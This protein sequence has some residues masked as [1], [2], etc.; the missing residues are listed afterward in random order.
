[1][2]YPK[3]AASLIGALLLLCPSASQAA[4]RHGAMLRVASLY[5]TPDTSS[6]KLGEIERGREVIV[7]DN[8]TGWLHVQALVTEERTV[9]AWIVDKGVVEPTTPNGDRILFG[10]AIDSEDQA[11]QRH[12]RRGAAG[13][14][15][16]LYYRVADLFPTSPLAG[17]AM[18]RSADIR[19]QIEKS[20]ASTRPSAKEQDAFLREGIDEQYMKEVMK[21]FPG[22]QWAELAAFRLIDNKLCGDWQGSSKCPDKEAEIYE[23]F[24]KD[25]PQSVAVPEALY[26]AAWRRAA[27]IEIYKTEEQKKK[28]D[29]SKVKATE[30][31]Q[32]VV[33]QFPQTDWASRAQTLLFLVQ[34]D[35]PTWGNSV[36]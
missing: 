3:I 8:S 17:E 19:W 2:Q 12:G 35:V 24:T 6:Q 34:Q 28:S 7:L 14:A 9:S 10:E 27:L 25:H 1:M 30:L 22:S 26:D 23:K 32:R 33:S 15:M 29:E 4:Y 5:L 31:A 36:Q 18:Y 21:K 20:D 13:D 16:R 11:S